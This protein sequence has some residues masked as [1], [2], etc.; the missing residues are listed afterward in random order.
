MPDK[1]SDNPTPFQLTSDDSLVDDDSSLEDFEID[2]SDVEPDGLPHGRSMAPLDE[3]DP[4]RRPRIPDLLP[5]LAIRDT[6]VFPGTIVPLTVGREKSK[7]LVADIVK[8]SKVI[9]VVAQQRG[10]VEDPTL[11]DLY[12]VGTVVTVLKKLELGDGSQSIIV[13]GLTR[14]GIEELTQTDPY[15]IAR[16]HP[17]EDT[18]IETTELEALI[19]TAK[20]LARRVIELTPGV[21]E[22]AL[23]IMENIAKPGSLADF[24]AANLSMEIV[25]KQ[26]MLETFDVPARFRKINK[27]L[28]TQLEILELSNKIHSQVK[29]QIDKTQREYYLQEQLQAIQK[30]LGVSDGREAEMARLK[31]AIEKAKMPEVV[32]KEAMRELERLERTHQASP[33][34]SGAID[35]LEWLIELP[36]SLSTEDKLDINEARRILDEDHFDLDKVKRRILEFL[37]VRKLNPKGKG[38]ILCFS[39]PP[40]VGKTS[41]GRSIARALGRKFIRMSVGGVRDEA[42]IR[43]HRRTYI[44]SIPGR[45]I[46]EIRKAGSNNPVYMIDEVDKIGNDFRGDPASA[47][48]EVLDPAQNDTFQDHYLG[49]PFDLSNVMFIATANYME[50]VPHALRDRMEVIDIAGYTSLDK[51]WIAKKYLVPRR[52]ESAGL[53]KHKIEFSDEALKLIIESYTSEAGV[54]NLER[55]I[56]GVCRAVAALIAEDKKAPKKITPQHVREYLGPIQFEAELAL[57]TSLPGVVTGLAWTPYGG[58]ILFVEATAMPGR[59]NLQMTGQL[60]DVMRESAQAALSVLKSKAKDFGIDPERFKDRDIHIHVPAGA[61]PKDGPSAG[62]AMITALV[63]LLTD[64]ACRA[65]V[66]MTGEITLRGLVLPIGGLKEKALAAH[67]AGIKTIILPARNEKN[68]VDIPEEIRREIE[69]VPVERVEQVLKRALEPKG[70]AKAS[71][72]KT[73]KAG[74]GRKSASKSKAVLKKKPARKPVARKRVSKSKATKRARSK[75]R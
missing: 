25:R 28:A 42:D 58:E 1:D 68:L 53:T 51:L 11:D 62:V 73:T 46:Q 24:L 48:L 22:E 27:A 66:A 61:V 15:L 50:R 8:G 38:T 36:W 29:S 57:R 56:G 14:F 21:P 67:R 12:R 13:H 32:E 30:E 9:G 44:G 19:E 41:L 7:L 39:G 3:P 31:E 35:Y 65:D 63:S 69:F 26:E 43:G 71:G 70:A 55:E 34:Y 54:R 16:A 49:V 2:L 40:G 6:V 74:A 47:L 10:E 59:G 52:T 33:E 23:T 64:R 5:I 75:S 37:A 72:T 45:V 17:R 60:G 18:F 20:R 4:K